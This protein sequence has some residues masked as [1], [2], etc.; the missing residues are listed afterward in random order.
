VKRQGDAD[1][2]AVRQYRRGERADDA[3]RLEVH[4]HRP[5]SFVGEG[6]AEHP[7]AKTSA[8]RRLHQGVSH[9]RPATASSSIPRRRSPTHEHADLALPHPDLTGATTADVASAAA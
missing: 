7:R 5:T 3:S 6:S 8:A 9:L 1:G 4:S 2:C